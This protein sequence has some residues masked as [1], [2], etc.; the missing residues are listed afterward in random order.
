MLALIDEVVP[1][2]QKAA[3]TPPMASGFWSDR[4]LESS[5][6]PF[7]RLPKLPAPIGSFVYTSPRFNFLDPAD[8]LTALPL[9]K[10]LL[11]ALEGG[12]AKRQ[13]L[14]DKNA[15]SLFDDYG[16]SSEL[17]NSFLDPLIKALIFRSPGQLSALVVLEVLWTYALKFQ[18]SFDIRWFRGPID[19][20]LIAPIIRELQ[21]LG[22]KIKSGTR[23]A[24]LRVDDT[25][26]KVCSLELSAN[27]GK[28][29]NID[30]E[31]CILCTGITGLKRIVSNCPDLA[32]LSP[33]IATAVDSLGSVDCTAVRLVLDRRCHSRF[34]SNVFANLP[35]L[36][37]MGATYFILERTQSTFRTSKYAGRSVVA[38]DFYGS[39]E[40]RD[41][42]D[43]VL[44]NRTL[45]LLERAEPAA[46]AGASVL[47]AEVLRAR[48]AAT[49][50]SPGSRR[51]RPSQ[52]TSIPNL[53]LAG[54]FVR[55]L[56]SSAGLSQERALSAG[57][58]AANLAMAALDIPGQPPRLRQRII[59]S[60]PD[61]PHVAA[62][63]STWNTFQ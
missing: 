32:R 62:V 45:S 28:L 56:D 42:A 24:G 58:T 21:R 6:P 17:R 20:V 16:I 38:V 63:R 25:S 29:A 49:E 8:R 10:P 46:F 9:L 53:F 3:L 18:N 59:P 40:L 7:N 36:G 30:V 57:Y 15:E 52:R 34:A 43:D 11:D 2:G 23:L 19:E 13:E 4:G 14:D 39:E 61:E 41:V 55:G 35:G 47:Q 50:F 54:D 33:E 37:E 60:F 27:D 22:V 12:E 5:A 44:V 48:G 26:G 31:A 1:G 51:V